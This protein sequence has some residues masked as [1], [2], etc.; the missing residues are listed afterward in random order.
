MERLSTPKE[1]T[2]VTPKP[3]A[4]PKPKP[5]ATKEEVKATTDN[6]KELTN[7][8]DNTFFVEHGMLQSDILAADSAGKKLIF[9][10]VQF[11][12]VSLV[13]LGKMSREN[14]IAYQMD[15]RYADKAGSRMAEGNNPYSDV[16]EELRLEDPLGNLIQGSAFEIKD[17]NPNMKYLFPDPKNVEGMLRAGYKL[18]P[19]SEGATVPQAVKKGDRL[20][21]VGNDGKVDNVAMMVDAEKYAKHDAVKHKRSQA[22]LGQHLESTKDKL[23]KY[24]PK[25]NIYDKS[26]MYKDE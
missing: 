16:R 18:V 6:L 26:K 19:E 10:I 3:T 1:E 20:C 2:K 23:Q 5:K 12:E 21:I 22:R 15:A 11:P 24:A 8:N 25:V 17:G 9:D 13:T 7:K 14:Q 4:K